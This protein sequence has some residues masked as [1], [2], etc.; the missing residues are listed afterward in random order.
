MLC[1]F[2]DLDVASDDPRVAAVADQDKASAVMTAAVF[3][4]LVARASGPGLSQNRSRVHTRISLG[5]DVRFAA[6]IKLQPSQ[7]SRVKG[8]LFGTLLN[9]SSPQ[10]DR[11]MKQLILSVVL[12]A[13]FGTGLRAEPF[14]EKQ[15]LFTVG[16]DPAYNI[17]HIPG[18]GSP[19]VKAS[20]P[21]APASPRRST[22]SIRARPGRPARSPCPTPKSGSIRMKPS[23]WS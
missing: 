2:N 8:T 23:P 13:V 5:P 9:T 14:F 4:S 20:M 18:I 12:F 16:E 15:D 6:M 3:A 22:A 21:T 10:P 17:Y 1:F 11:A 7:A 19:P